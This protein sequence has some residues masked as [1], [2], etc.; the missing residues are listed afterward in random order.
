[1]RKLNALLLLG[2][3][4]PVQVWAADLKADYNFQNTLNSSVGI[5]PALVAVGSGTAGFGTQTVNGSPRTVYTSTGDVSNGAAGLRAQTNGMINPN[6]YSLVFY[7]QFNPVG[8]AIAKLIDYKNLTSD[9]GLYNV[10]NI[11]TFY[12]STI[13]VG[14]GV[15]PFPVDASFAQL[16]LTRDAASTVSVYLNGTPQFSFVDT[17]GLGVIDDPASTDEFLHFFFDD[18]QNTILT[19]GLNIEDATGAVARLRLYD[20]AL[21]SAEIAALDTIPEPSSLLAAAGLC[22][23]LRRNRTA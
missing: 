2:M 10:S 20:G 1:M 15:T 7:A 3:V 23:L 22:L 11:P 6:T 12:N 16:V 18:N 5:A 21:T 8:T 13:P 4:A 19:N 14:N 17:T 9:A